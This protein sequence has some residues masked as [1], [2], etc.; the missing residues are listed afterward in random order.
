[1]QQPLQKSHHSIEKNS[2]NL[3]KSTSITHP[4][5]KSSSRILIRES[6][7]ME[8]SC[9]LADFNL[10][11]TNSKSNSILSLSRNIRRRLMIVLNR[12]KNTNAGFV[13]K[14]SAKERRTSQ[15]PVTITIGKKY[16][17]AQKVQV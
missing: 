16:K 13:S 3:N 12:R 10:K 5:P 6:S 7:M 11:R 4:V 17:F 9:S 8:K 1:M 14:P 15:R 2:P